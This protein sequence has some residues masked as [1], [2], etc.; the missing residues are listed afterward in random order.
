MQSS[1]PARHCAEA[2]VH[3]GPVAVGVTA[4]TTVLR[5][6]M[7]AE[8]DQF[9]S[10]WT[11]PGAMVRVSLY[12]TDDSAVAGEG[13]FLHCSAMRVDRTRSGLV[14]TCRSG[15]S[16]S[17]DAAQR[18]W[19]LRIR[20]API[21]TPDIDTPGAG[22]AGTA[23]EDNVE[24]L[25][26]LILTTAWRDVGWIALHAAG[27][28]DDGRC[29]LLMAPAR[30]GKSTL[31]AAMLHRGWHTLG[32][33]KLLLA[34]GADGRPEVRGLTSH[35]NLD[36]RTRAWFPEV[37]DLEPLPRLSNWSAKRRVPIEAV[38][39]ECFAPRAI[40]THVV[41]IRRYPDRRPTRVEPLTASEVL[42]AVLHQSVVP[43]DAATARVILGV[44]ARSARRLRGV[45]F[46]IGDDAYDDP[47]SLDALEAGMR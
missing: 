8:L 31:T 5:E 21:A 17:Y 13:R 42:S 14:A 29:A 6:R 24:D 33:D 46:E 44:L 18:R 22:L 7:L 40:P 32:D 39:G 45:R 19:E 10:R 28:V 16:G 34:L 15:S 11:D 2:I 12:A 26:E 37:G 20:T 25:L 35:F 9:T 30:G 36:P 43:N 41:L 4:E 47:A 38:W 1:R 3:C 23:A 27:V